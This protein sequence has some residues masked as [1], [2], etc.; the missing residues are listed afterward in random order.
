MAFLV[1]VKEWFCFGHFKRGVV[2]FIICF[3]LNVYKV[4]VQWPSMPN[5]PPALER[6]YVQLRELPASA[7][8][9][10]KPCKNKVM[11]M[12]LKAADRQL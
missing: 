6:K 2:F 12:I 11:G 1:I 10:I 4:K 5:L 8:E 3:G 9:T 7:K